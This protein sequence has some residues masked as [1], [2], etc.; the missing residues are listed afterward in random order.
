ME[1]WKNALKKF[2]EHFGYTPNDPIEISDMQKKY[3]EILE[4]SVAENFDY[5]IEVYGTNPEKNKKYD[6]EAIIID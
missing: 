4:R 2:I 5:T 3:P 1:R 6:K